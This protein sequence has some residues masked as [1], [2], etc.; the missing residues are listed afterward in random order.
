MKSVQTSGIPDQAGEPSSTPTV[1]TRVV[2]LLKSI[3]TGIRDLNAR[4]DSL[5]KRVASISSNTPVLK[6]QTTPSTSPRIPPFAIRSD[7]KVLLS[8]AHLTGCDL[9]EREH[10]EGVVLREPEMSNAIDHLA[11]RFDETAG[12]AAGKLLWRQAGEICSPVET[13]GEAGLATTG[14]RRR[15]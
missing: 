15:R 3:E 10:W 1:E 13:P 5:E 7:G 2:A 4:V 11:D 14:D 12:Y 9:S 8:V 6:E